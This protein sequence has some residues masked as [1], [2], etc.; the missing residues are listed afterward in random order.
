MIPMGAG[1]GPSIE[2]LLG[3]DSMMVRALTLNGALSGGDLAWSANQRD[4][5]A[6]EL[7]AANGVANAGSLARLVRRTHR[8]GR[9]RSVGGTPVAGADRSCPHAAD[10]GCRP[11][12]VVPRHRRRVDDRARLLVGIS[13]RAV[14]RPARVRPLGAGG[15]VGFADPEHHV[16]GGYVMNKMSMAISADPRSSAL[17]R[18]SYEAAGADHHPRLTALAPPP[19]KSSSGAGSWACASRR[20]PRPFLGVVGREHGLAVLELVGERLLLGHA[21][22]LVERAQDRLDRERAV[23]GDLLGDL[24]APWRAPGRR[25][26]RGR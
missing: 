2:D 3:A 4:F 9:R 5:R 19:P 25:G 16:A 26:R 1:D 14:R 7:P 13:V 18:A 8:R 21:V 11:G 23:V 15:S 22:G 24:L 12:A 10:G 17:I 6:A 20:R